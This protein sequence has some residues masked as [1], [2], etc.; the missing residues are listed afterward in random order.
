MNNK[1]CKIEKKQLIG[2]LALFI[3]A[4][5]WGLGF[6]A[7]KDALDSISPYYLL[8]IRFIFATLIMAL[9]F[10]K[11]IKAITK[12]DLFAGFIIGLFLFAGFA[13]QTIGIKYTTA[14]N[15]AFLTGVNVIMVPFLVWLIYKKKPD[16]YSFI[17]ALL[18]I[19]GIGL[20]TIKSDFVFNFG[21]LLTLLC[22]LF[23]AMHIVSIGNYAKKH[24]PI[25][26]TI[27]QLGYTA[28][29]STIAALLFE[30]A[31]QTINM[32]IVLS[33]VYQILFATVFAFLIQ[34]IAQKITSSSH[35]AIILSTESVFGTIFAVLILKEN[36]TFQMII[37]FILI[38]ISIITITTKPN[39]RLSKNVETLE[40]TN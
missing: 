7:V 9:I 15:S 36:L 26:L 38:F 23:F 10:F 25:I 39:I 12:K 34:N 18:S 1:N 19:V 22:A 32:D 11:K 28:V 14:S 40:N 4:I 37:G 33:S 13:T 16:I 8:S 6:I 17:G 24:D 2:D 3:V 21:D 29:F 35:T 31:P 20:I 5:F 27:L 30:T